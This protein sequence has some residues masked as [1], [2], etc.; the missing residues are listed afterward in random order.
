MFVYISKTWLQG[1][2][3]IPVV[4]LTRGLFYFLKHLHASQRTEKGFQLQVLTRKCSKKRGEE[5]L[6]L[7]E[8]GKFKFSIFVF[9]RKLYKTNLSQMTVFFLRVWFVFLGQVILNFHQEMHNFKRIGAKFYWKCIL[10]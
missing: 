7:F 4:K 8:L 3:G 5:N 6:P 2:K 1:F 9:N 10:L